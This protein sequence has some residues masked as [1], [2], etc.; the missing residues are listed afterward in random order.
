MGIIQYMY[1]KVEKVGHIIYILLEKSQL[2]LVIEANPKRKGYFYKLKV[3]EK[4]VEEIGNH[5]SYV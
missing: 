2:S 3:P 1:F 4:A 5:C